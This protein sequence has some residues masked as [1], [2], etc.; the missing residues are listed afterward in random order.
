MPAIYPPARQQATPP[1]AFGPSIVEFIEL[2][3]VTGEESEPWAPRIAA[4]QNP[5][6]GGVTVYRSN[7]TGYDFV[8]T[9]AQP[10]AMGALAAPLYAGPVGRWD[11][12][13]VVTVQFYGDVT[14]QSRTDEGVLAGINA[15][16]VKNPSN[17]DW[18]VIQFATATLVAT[19]KYALSRLLRG[20]LGTEGAMGNPVAAGT[21]C[22]FLDATEF[23]ILDMNVDQRGLAQTLSYGPANKDQADP[24]Y[25]TATIT[26]KGEGLRP[27][28]VDGITG[29]LVSATG[30]WVVTWV[31]RTRYGGDSFDLA[32]VP[33]NEDV[34]QYDLEVVG[35][36]GTVL[37]TATVNAPAWTYTRAMQIADFGAPQ[38]SFRVNIYQDS[39]I[40]GRGQVRSATIF[41]ASAD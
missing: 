9:V 37:R 6:P 25:Q 5:W 10:A 19:N 41:E 3:L 24:A 38:S 17:G 14:L 23:G 11:R 26:V 18:E 35:G 1:D 12:G 31:R 34:E 22:V 13:N 32:I 8:T 2:P 29:M 30:D 28:S 39:V 40:Y 7:G 16:A 15:I 4:Y 33:L 36:T 21:R 20:Q 27:Y